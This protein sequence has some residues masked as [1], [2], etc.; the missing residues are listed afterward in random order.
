MKSGMDSRWKLIRICIAA[1]VG[2]LH[3]T[4][5]LFLVFR[6]ETKRISE[7]PPAGVMKLVDLREYIPPPPP[8]P[9]EPPPET[10]I[11]DTEE[12]IA[13]RL[14]ESDEAP[15]PKN[16]PPVSAPSDEYAEPEQ[17]EYIPQEDLT[18]QPVFPNAEIRRAV[19]YPPIAQR[20]G[21]KGIVYMELLIER[22][23]TI[24]G[25]RILR[26]NPAGRG[27]GEAATNALR[28]IRV[29]PGERN[30]TAVRCRYR[31]WINFTL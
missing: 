14:V 4:L 16:I 12:P 19:V 11:V 2:V 10:P 13:E 3:I 27:F 6:V 23:G 20:A 25:I 18:Q 29:K 15:A 21:I 8:P 28:G 1:A 7:E 22:E 24:S 31:Y 9:P 17:I 30:G 5:L 26:E